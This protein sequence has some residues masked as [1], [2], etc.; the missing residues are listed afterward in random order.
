M[1]GLYSDLCDNKVCY[2]WTAPYLAHENEITP[3]YSM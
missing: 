2:K 1:T 3:S